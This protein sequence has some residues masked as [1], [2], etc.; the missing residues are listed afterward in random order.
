LLKDTAQVG[1]YSIA[2]ILLVSLHSLLTV[3]WG[4]TILPA[5][6]EAQAKNGLSGM[7]E[8]LNI[9]FKLLILVILPAVMF[10]GYY[11]NTFIL[12]LFGSIYSPSI[13]LLKTYILFDILTIFFMG[14]VT[15]FSLY[16]IDK[17]KLVL[18][19]CILSGALNIILDFVLIPLYGALG[20]IIATGISIAIFSLLELIL[21]F[22][23]I[24]I[25][26]PYRFISKVLL[27]GI[28]CLSSLSW[29]KTQ[30]LWSLFVIGILYLILLA[31]SFY[32]LKILEPQDKELL[33]KLNPRFASVLRYF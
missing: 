16:V 21:I 5:L 12:G 20:A 2:A 19:L 27:A 26:Y 17:E 3:G 33:I 30:N 7:V 14:G 6:S 4:T 11:A 10:L 29:I 13:H 24:P 18:K 31:A 8:I 1:Y 28:I 32:L 23:Y 9:Y 25:K 15:G 22:K